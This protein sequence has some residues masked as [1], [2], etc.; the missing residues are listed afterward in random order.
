[1]HVESYPYLSTLLGGYFHQDAYDDG[2]T[3]EDI[4]RDFI[5][6][7]WDYQRLGIRADIKRLLHEHDDHL[8]EAIQQAFRPAVIVGRND[9]EARAWLLKIERM[10]EQES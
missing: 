1:M 10:L 7:S 8:L 5:G 6:S 4:V 3:E 2:A 9:D